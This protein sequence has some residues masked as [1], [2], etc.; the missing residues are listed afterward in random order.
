[1][2]SSCLWLVKNGVPFD[3]AFSLSE[4]ERMAYCIN[5]GTFEGNVWDY[6]SMAWVKR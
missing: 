6:E 5:F 4:T 1:V 2:L 3:V